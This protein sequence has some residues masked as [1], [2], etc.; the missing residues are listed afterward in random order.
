MM[1]TR[2]GEESSLT[3]RQFQEW[4]PTTR[5]FRVCCMTGFGRKLPVG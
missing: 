2:N 1:I 3:V 4:R 5:R